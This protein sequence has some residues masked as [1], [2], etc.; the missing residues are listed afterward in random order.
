MVF[1]RISDEI[2]GEE[3]QLR[4]LVSGFEDGQVRQVR[5]DAPT[6]E[7]GNEVRSPIIRAPEEREERMETGE[8]NDARGTGGAAKT[9]RK[10]AASYAKGGFCKNRV[11]LGVRGR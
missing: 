7:G 11:E 8:R 10:R 2:N 9:K 5:Q 3:L 4:F 1:F 6:R